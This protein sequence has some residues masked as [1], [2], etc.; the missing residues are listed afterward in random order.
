MKDKK[1]QDV[2]HSSIVLIPFRV[3]K[4]GGTQSPLVHLETVD[5]YG[6][7]NPTAGGPLKGR[8]KTSFWAEPGQIEVTQ[9]QAAAK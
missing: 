8:T 5:A 9:D 4:V 1:G 7:E 2:Q 3:I 6:H